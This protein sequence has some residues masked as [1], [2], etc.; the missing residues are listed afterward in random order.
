VR[1]RVIAGLAAALLAVGLVPAASGAS[2]GRP[3]RIQLEVSALEPLTGSFYEVWVVTGERK[4]S[5]G[6]FNV[7][8]DGTLVDGFGHEARFFSRVDPA[9]ADAIVVTIEPKPDPDRG[10]SGIA[11]LSGTPRRSGMAKLRFPV[12]F[13]DV[14]GSFILAT[15]TSSATNDETAGVWFLDPDA[16]PG[17]SL[18]VP[19][20]PDGWVYE[21]WGVTQGTPLTTGRFTSPSGS[22]DAAPFSGPQPGPPFPGEDFLN[23]LPQGVTPPVDLANGGSSVVLTVEP[24]LAGDDP[25]GPA[26]FSIKPL[27]AMVAAGAA[28][29]TSIELGRDLS[30]VPSGTATF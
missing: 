21:G 9:S 15:P 27:L 4:I 20:L 30:T 16:G 1:T 13:G 6:S 18:D 14:S 5:A 2:A 26:P 17:P 23:D 3:F 24:D 19:M 10:P 11:V 28:D 8:D 22:D 12:R 25:T 29:H 7:A